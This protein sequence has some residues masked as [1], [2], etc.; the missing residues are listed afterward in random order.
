MAATAETLRRK[1]LM[2]MRDSPSEREK[3][4]EKSEKEKN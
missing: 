2:D 1:F 4:R 3:V